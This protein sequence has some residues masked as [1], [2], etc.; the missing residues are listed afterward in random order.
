MK[1][2]LRFGAVEYVKK[3]KTQFVERLSTHAVG[4]DVGIGPY[5][6]VR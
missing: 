6:V 4:S 3:L 1:P 5:E 2:R